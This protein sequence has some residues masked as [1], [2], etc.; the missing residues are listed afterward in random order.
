MEVPRM[1]HRRQKQVLVTGARALGTSVS[2]LV[3]KYEALSNESLRVCSGSST[4]NEAHH[5]SQS[6][7]KSLPDLSPIFSREGKKRASC[8]AF[9]AHGHFLACSGLWEQAKLVQIVQCIFVQPLSLLFCSLFLLLILRI[10]NLS[11]GLR[12][13]VQATLELKSIVHNC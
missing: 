3:R 1:E 13:S 12:F 7:G 5:Q 10:V 6:L 9:N 8:N 2:S 11:Q 4:D